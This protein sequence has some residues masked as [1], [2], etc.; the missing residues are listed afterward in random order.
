METNY[1]Q[2]VLKVYPDAFTETVNNWFCYNSAIGIGIVRVRKIFGLPIP[3][4]RIFIGFGY[5]Q[6]D[7]WESAYN[8]NILNQKQ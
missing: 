6:I 1:K 8:N 5:T 7:A 3:F 2:E 4:T